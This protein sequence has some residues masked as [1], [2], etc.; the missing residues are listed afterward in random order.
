[1]P[2]RSIF[3]AGRIVRS[4]ALELIKRLFK[5][6]TTRADR[7][8]AYLHGAVSLYDLEAREREIA[9]GKFAGY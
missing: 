4:I 3:T 6:P 1:M 7:E 9:R 5:G 8:L 2:R